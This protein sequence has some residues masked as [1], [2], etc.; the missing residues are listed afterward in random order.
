MGFDAG[1]QSVKVA[2]CDENFNLIA[3]RSLATTL[4]YPHPGW[5]EMDVENYLENCLECMRLVAEGKI[6]TTPL[7]THT[8]AFSELDRAYD[9]FGRR[10]DGVMKVAVKM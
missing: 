8:F 1:T 5:V 4:R 6:D 9:L 3:N 7:I 10:A 2:V